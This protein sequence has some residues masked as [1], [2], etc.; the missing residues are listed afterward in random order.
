[1]T[2]TVSNRHYVIP[3]C[4]V[5]LEELTVA[6]VVK[7]LPIIYGTWNFITALTRACH[8]SSAHPDTL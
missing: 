3:W 1:M 7:K 5:D 6:Q 8:W 4:K 2:V